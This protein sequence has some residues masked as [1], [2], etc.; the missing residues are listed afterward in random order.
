MI[1]GTGKKAL[2]GFL[3]LLVDLA[4]ELREFVVGVA[5]FV[6]GLLEEVGD[7]SLA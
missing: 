7:F 5:F 4:G 3:R 2:S 1:N 6:E